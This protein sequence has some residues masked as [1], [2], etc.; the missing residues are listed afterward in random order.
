MAILK[1]FKGLRPPKTSVLQVAAL[2]YDVVNSAE[3]RAYAEG[4]P[5]SFFQVSRPEIGL[6]AGTDEHS[7]AVYQRGAASLTD[8]IARGV[9]VQDAKAHFYVYRQQMGAHVQTGLVA[10]ASVDE[11]DAAKIKKHELTRA[12][13]EDDRTHHIDALDANDEP[14]FLAYRAVPAIDALIASV[15]SQAPEYA[16]TTDDGIGHTFWVADESFNAKLDARFRE[17]DA[18]YIAD[19]HH[20][21]AAASRVHALRKGKAGNHGGFLAVVFPHDQLQILDYNR[22]VKDL[23]GATPEQFLSKVSEKFTVEKTTTAKPAAVHHFGMFLGGQWYGLTAKLGTW[24]ETPTGVLDVS[25]LQNNVLEPLL[26][27]GDPRLDKR[28]DFVGGIRG[29]AELEKR[30]KSGSA[31]V[32]FAMFPTT[33][34]QLMAIADAGEIMP[35]KSTWF[36]PKLRS[37]LVVHPF[38]I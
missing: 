33:L 7:D 11:Y 38:A 23:N 24:A 25:I 29:T 3:A 4:K 28:I 13:K 20:R 15:T 31:A 36:E 19:G 2:P 18:L 21:S 5:D 35:P 30:V 9:L 16:F 10:A 17:V 26:G 37:G 14:V 6:P 32:A 8:F 27:I 22:L 12:D 34:E 1:P